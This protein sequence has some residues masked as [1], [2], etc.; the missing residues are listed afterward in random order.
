VAKTLIDIDG[1][2]L[3]EAA[4]VLRTATKKATVNRALA[5]VVALAGR[6][7]HLAHLAAGGLPDLGDADVMRGAWRD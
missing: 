4:R 7:D 5:E 2:L 3:A 1:E 6:D